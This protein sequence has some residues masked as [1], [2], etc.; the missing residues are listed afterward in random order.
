[1]KV[2]IDGVEYIPMPKAQ[3]TG[4]IH[5]AALNLR[6]DSDVGFITMFNICAVCATLQW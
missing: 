1:M 5:L 2:T 3:D 4:D 6:F